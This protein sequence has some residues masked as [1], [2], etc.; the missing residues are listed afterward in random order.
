MCI[1]IYKPQDKKISYETLQQ[2]FKSNPDGAGFMYADGKQL[3]MQK[4]FFTFEDFWKAYKKHEKKQA[5]IH[6][7]I[8][9]HGSINEEN[10]HPFLINNSIGFVHNGVIS[11]FGIEDK[12]DTN[13]FNE[14]I[15]K[16]LVSKWGNL[17]LFQPAIKSLIESR[18]GYSKLIF[19]DR[20]GNYDI[21]NESKG[22]WDNDV[23]YSNTSYKPYLPPKQ[24][25]FTSYGS[26]GTY[27]PPAKS[28]LTSPKP[29]TSYL[30]E[31]DL[32]KLTRAFFDFETKQHFAKDEIFEVI[33]VNSYYTCDLMME[34]EDD[35]NKSF[36]YN[37]PFSM[38]ELIIED[39][40]LVA[41][42]N[43]TNWYN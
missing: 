29:V 35:P 31:G 10:C 38:L 18:I 11:G 40:E 20:H 1:A 12:S 22:V 14:D 25:A 23:W 34:N 3:Q 36:A 5:V 24:M 27:V 37:V 39:D 7:R 42:Y 28:A 26:P 21:F 33:A 4:G 2:C 9:T 15:L 13:H 6:F 30:K 16:P 17:S 32:V 19:L 41:E 8:K 43:P